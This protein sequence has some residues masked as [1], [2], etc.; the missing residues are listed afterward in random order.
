[1]SAMDGVTA[2]QL[3]SVKRHSTIASCNNNI[4]ALSVLGPTAK[5]DDC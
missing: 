1:M 3:W 4:F 2:H 5:F